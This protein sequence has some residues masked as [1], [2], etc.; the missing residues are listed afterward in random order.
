MPSRVVLKTF[1]YRHEAEVLKGFL[2]ASGIDS[3]IVSDD[4]GAVDPALEYGRGT[5]LLVAEEDLVR[6]VEALSTAEA[7]QVE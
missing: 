3:F 2:A 6:A 1:N 4:C 7:G 5:H